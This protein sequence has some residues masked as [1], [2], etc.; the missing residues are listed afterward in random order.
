MASILDDIKSLAEKRGYRL[1]KR[2][3]ALVIIHPHVPVLRVVAAIQGDK[4]ILSLDTSGL[5]DYLDDLVEERGAEEARTIVEDALDDVGELAAQ[6]E[7]L[8]RR[9]GVRLENRIRS[10]TLDVLDELEDVLEM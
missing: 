2:N 5:R 1:E 7:A 8:A 6:V 9:Y 4:L 3:S 10:G